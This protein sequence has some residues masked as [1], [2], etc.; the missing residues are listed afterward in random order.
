MVTWVN[1]HWSMDFVSAA[2]FDGRRIR[3]LTMLDKLTRE[4]LPIMLDGCIHGEHVAQSVERIAARRGAPEL[5]R[6]DDGPDF[7]SKVLDRWTYKLGV[8]LDFSRPGKPTDNGFIE[9]LNGRLRDERLD[10]HWFLS[11]DD[12]RAKIEA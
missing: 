8:T 6:V 9:S 7:V 2:L 5:I 11:L 12:A 1:Q 4:A 10:A 3:A